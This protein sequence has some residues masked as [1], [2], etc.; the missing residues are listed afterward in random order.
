MSFTYPIVVSAIFC[1][2][3]ARELQAVSSGISNQRIELQNCL[4]MASLLNAT[5]VIPPALLGT[6]IP[7]F[8]LEKM[9]KLLRIGI[10]TE[11]NPRS[12]LDK[13][14][15]GA[16]CINEHGKP[17]RTFVEWG[18]LINIEG[19][20]E[21]LGLKIVTWE[22]FASLEGIEILDTNI[23]RNSTLS[24]QT[25]VT[26]SDQ[27]DSLSFSDEVLYGYRFTESS[28]DFWGKPV[29]LA[30]YTGPL[31]NV[32]DLRAILDTLY[33]PDS[34]KRHV[35]QFGSMFGSHRVEV[36]SANSL[37]IA[38][39]IST[40]IL[41]LSNSRM[42]NV[43]NKVVS[44]LGGTGTYLGVHIRQGDGI[45]E[46]EAETTMAETLTIMDSWKRRHFDFT[47]DDQQDNIGRQ[48]HWPYD[49]LGPLSNRNATE[50]A[51][52]LDFH[53]SSVDPHIF[54]L[55]V[56][57]FSPLNVPPMPVVFVATDMARPRGSALFVTLSKSF[58]CTFY[59]SDFGPAL[60]PLEN[61]LDTVGRTN[62]DHVVSLVDQ[63]VVSM[64]GAFIGSRRSTFSALCARIHDVYRFHEE[65]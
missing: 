58:P 26:I 41:P 61:S 30:E 49:R 46:Q 29:E 60:V 63:A 39:E 17:T 38:H 22:E 31:V 56:S 9:R 62:S 48:I 28:T 25:I 32:R 1:N 33:P 14:K 4:I 7:W 53:S 18:D 44:L 45:F 2:W 50:A 64:G 3:C 13:H 11:R 55:L 52:L 40:Y 47:T 12:C 8:A 34:G 6:P 16:T 57:C 20:T 36:S 10:E 21:R 59:L 43:V 23:W 27:L 15:Y 54:P 19:L 42:V 35:I 24:S 37:Q 51:N 5:L 65:H